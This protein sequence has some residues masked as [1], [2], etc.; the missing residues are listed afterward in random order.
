MHIID[1]AFIL[2]LFVVQPIHGYFSYQKYMRRLANGEP[3][4]RVKL[5]C[6]TMILEWVAFAVLAIAWISLGRP[7]AELGFVS[8]TSMQILI[9]SGVLVLFTAYLLYTWHVARQ[10]TDA[11]K[12][13]QLDALGDLNHF[14][15]QDK[16]D[17]RHF[18]AVSVTAGIVEEILYRSYSFWFLAHFMP[19]WTV[20]LVSSIAFGL[21]HTYQGA[22]GVARVTLIGVAFGAFYGFTGSI[23][24]PM[25]A[26][27]I[28]DVLQGASLLEM[29]RRGNDQSLEQH[30]D[31][32]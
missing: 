31:H 5:Y 7:S 14:F 10:M 18:V 28:L 32:C 25:L 17:Y 1:Y 16:R 27:A 11:E 22:S 13:K 21:G 15:P 20:V 29:A 19:M 3:S 2:L 8:S 12:T 4:N 6:E 26:H 23:W 30:P 24:L 9:G